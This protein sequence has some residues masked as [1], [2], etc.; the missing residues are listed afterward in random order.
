[1]AE[2]NAN[3]DAFSMR[4]VPKEGDNWDSVQSDLFFDQ[5]EIVMELNGL[6]FVGAGLITDPETGVQERIELNVD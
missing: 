3:I 1:L 6:M 5:G 2:I 4:I